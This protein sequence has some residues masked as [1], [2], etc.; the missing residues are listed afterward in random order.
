M[1]QF[2]SVLLLLMNKYITPGEFVDGKKCAVVTRKADFKGPHRDPLTNSIMMLYELSRN[3]SV[4]ITQEHGED[5]ER[6]PNVHYLVGD[7]LE[8]GA[9]QLWVDTKRNNVDF[10]VK[11]SVTATHG[12]NL[13]NTKKR[14]IGQIKYPRSVFDNLLGYTAKPKL[15]SR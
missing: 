14:T 2:K 8:A 1:T 3:C 10:V 13:A 9:I 11:E 12:A 4:E 15:E 7:I 6:L 5:I